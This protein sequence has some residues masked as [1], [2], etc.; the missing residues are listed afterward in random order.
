MRKY[1][2]KKN[3]TK[4]FWVILLAI[5]LPLNMQAE[6]VEEPFDAYD[7]YDGILMTQISTFGGNSSFSFT[8]KKSYPNV[9]SV[10]VRVGVGDYLYGNEYS[11]GAMISVN[12]Q[13][14]DVTITNINRYKGSTSNLDMTELKFDL[15]EANTTVTL[16]GSIGNG[17][18]DFYIESAIVVYEK[19]DDFNFI[20]YPIWVRVWDV[21]ARAYVERQVTEDN[22]LDIMNDGGSVQYN[23]DKMIVLNNSKTTGGII[24]EME[25]MILY[26][27]G[28]N[29]IEG[30]SNMPLSFHGHYTIT[31]EGNNPGSL[32]LSVY[33]PSLPFDPESVTLEQNL[34]Y[35]PPTSYG[36][37]RTGK[38][39]V[40][41]DPLVNLSNTSREVPVTTNG[42]LDNK[43]YDDVLYNLKSEDG[44]GY[45][46]TTQ[47]ILMATTMHGEDVDAII[48][49]YKPGSYEYSQNFAGI[50]FL[51]PAGTGKAIVVGHTSDEGVLNVKIGNNTPYVI[52]SG[53][54]VG[55]RF[56]FPYDVEE[57]TYVYVYSD[58]PIK[59]VEA[60]G[61]RRAGKKTTVT[62]GVGSVG[63]EANTVQNSN[64]NPGDATAIK[65]ILSKEQKVVRPQ[66]WYSISGR[67]LQGVPTQKGL[68][69]FGGRKYV[70]K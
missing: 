10:V 21:D 35:I 39:C 12:G 30:S 61:D 27:K 1:L 16:G 5:F 38:I 55:T 51:V 40:P 49:N 41:I 8:S 29:K 37:V 70:I 60:A 52:P 47:S 53:V 15:N 24:S 43:V 54:P 23:G 31:T 14:R 22:R 65:T 2:S 69:I 59:T 19:D 6:M 4:S 7:Y 45:D 50:T 3:V 13:E 57:A 44:N 11:S 32:Q 9:V 64:P 25:D 67:C 68:Y 56:T 20:G 26:L 63:V 17:T 18:C 66:V 36:S 28:T 42:N 46:A 62:V 34:V 48:S 58:S 33:S